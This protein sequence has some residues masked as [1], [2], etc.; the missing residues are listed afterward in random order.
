MEVRAWC[1]LALALIGG[2][3]AKSALGV[4]AFEAMDAAVSADAGRDAPTFDTGADAGTDSGFDAG[5]DSGFDSATDSGSDAG[6]DSGSDAGH[7]AAVITIETGCADGEREAFRDLM[8]YPSIA[9]CAGGWTRPGLAHVAPAACGGQGGDDGPFASGSPCGA[10]DLC[11][12]RW[13]VCLGPHDVTLSSPDGCDGSHDAVDS[14]FATRMSGPGCGICATG[15]APDCTAT[16]CRED[17]AQTASTMNDIFGCGT[18]GSVPS[19]G[20]C[21]PLDRFGNNLCSSLPPPWSCAYDGS[22]THEAELVVKP[23]SAHGGIVCCR[24]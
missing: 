2:C 18:E 11:A 10:S 1:W 14:F 21:G 8:R 24:D 23:G 16:D 9:G 5:P 17:C 4:G 12:P 19:A 7:D 3:G 15:G 6:R 20:T 22:G 13:H